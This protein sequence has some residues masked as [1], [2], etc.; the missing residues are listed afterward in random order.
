M[1]GLIG[2]DG[3]GKSSLLSLISGA[4]QIQGGYVEALDGDMA[5][6]RHRDRVGP[7]CLYAPRF[8]G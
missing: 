6:M 7:H 3:V 1:I 2:P 5:D 4:R 8:R